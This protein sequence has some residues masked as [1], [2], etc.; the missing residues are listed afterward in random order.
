MGESAISADSSAKTRANR[1][2]TCLQRVLSNKNETEPNECHTGRQKF[3]VEHYAARTL[4][5]SKDKFVGISG[6]AQIIQDQ[7]SDEYIAG[8]WRK[9]PRIP[10]MLGEWGGRSKTH[11]V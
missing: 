3:I 8:M 1:I 5:Y 4:T 2:W 7:T 6:L 10:A 11:S 9:K